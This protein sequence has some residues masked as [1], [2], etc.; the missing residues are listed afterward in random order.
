MPQKREG[1]CGG[2][3]VGVGGEGGGCREGGGERGGDGGG[4]EEGRK[5]IREEL[6]RSHTSKSCGKRKNPSARARLIVCLID[7][8]YTVGHLLTSSISSMWRLTSS[9]SAHT[10][11][12]LLH[13]TGITAEC[14]SQVSHWKQQ[15]ERGS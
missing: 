3:G 6:R 2:V 9:T 5:G 7:S 14:L 13:I 15:G 8:R 11:H 12:Y 10:C 4:R 1:V